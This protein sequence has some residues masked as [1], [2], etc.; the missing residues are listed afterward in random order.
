[1]KAPYHSTEYVRSW[2][3]R[4]PTYEHLT[5]LFRFSQSLFLFSIQLPL[6]ALDQLLGTSQYGRP[7]WTFV[8][9]CQ[10]LLVSYAVW[11]LNPATRPPKDVLSDE[12][13]QQIPKLNPKH[14][15]SLVIVPPCP[16][17]LFGDA[18][19][20]EVKPETCP[21]FWQWTDDMPGESPLEG[22]T[23][24]T[25]KKV[26]M[27]FVG[28]GMVQGHPVNATFPFTVASTI[29]RPVFGVNFRK[30]VT[31]KTAFPAALQDAVAAFFYLIDQGFLPENIS[32]MGDSGGAGIAITT[33]LYLRRHKL[34]MPGNAILSS[35]FVD[36]V[37]DFHSDAELLNLDFV[38]PEMMSMVSYQYTENRP[39]LRGTLLSPARGDLPEGYSFEGFPRT[40]LVWGEVELFKHGI[41]RF[42]ESLKKAGVEVDAMEGKDYV[43]DWAMFTKD[44]SQEGAYG[45]IRNFMR[46][47]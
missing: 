3:A 25:R 5:R 33:L 27:Y 40:F 1:M 31:K 38:N 43:H 11:S 41:V 21:C 10:R 44:K 45:R 23:L 16:D 8:Q 47:G 32:I 37:D 12:A 36:L 46:N 15:A 14:H 28:G 24:I 30:C 9:R 34:P 18:V 22:K 42:V 17:K 4:S 7:S 39:Y 20:E 13:R 35:P 6:I 29:R 26:I 19:H 2:Q